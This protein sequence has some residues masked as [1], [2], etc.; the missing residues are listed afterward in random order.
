MYTPYSKQKQEVISMSSQKRMP[1]IFTGH[2]SPMN[3]IGE[4]KARKGWQDMGKKIG[5]PEVIIAVSAHWATRGLF[6]RQADD[7][8]QIN[9]MYGFP[10]ELYQVHYAPAGSVKFSGRALELLNGMASV[11]ND[12]GIDHGIWSVLSNMYPDADI[13]VVMVSTDVTADA[14]AQF[15]AGKR[16][17]ALRDEGAVI[18]ASGNVV[19]NLHMVNW[20]MENG[21]EWADAFDGKIRDAIVQENH[22]IP[23]D[24]KNVADWQK[25]IPTVEHYYPLLAA[26]GAADREDKVT[27]WNE[28]REL[29]SMSMTSYLF[30]E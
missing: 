18:I 15:E 9:D 19:H 23:V 29:G 12:W 16:L 10:A 4:N 26:L 25:A 27:I 1:V 13:P 8:P 20:D 3:A 30:G 21:Y 17:K 24:Y 2:G 5:R 7:N 6:V 14:A 28:Y 22:A 11:N